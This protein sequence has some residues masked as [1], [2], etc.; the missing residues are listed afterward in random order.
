MSEG[1]LPPA[2]YY[3]DPE[4]PDVQR[5]WDGAQWATPPPPP[6]SATPLPILAPSK[7]DT[8]TFAIAS[9]ILGLTWIWFVGSVLAVIFGHVAIAQIKASGGR[10]GGRGLAIVGL[11]VGYI[12][13]AI[14]V[15][16][17]LLLVSD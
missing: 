13:V 4:T 17:A 5:W 3:P 2:G 9:L 16:V 1:G 12:G 11:I 6:P 8:N 10:E 7:P 14:L 15:F